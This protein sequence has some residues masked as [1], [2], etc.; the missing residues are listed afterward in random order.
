MDHLVTLFLKLLILTNEK[1]SLDPL[2][3]R[4]HVDMHGRVE[5]VRGQFSLCVFDFALS[6]ALRSCEVGRA[7]P[8]VVVVG[9]E[10]HRS[11]L[12]LRIIAARRRPVLGID[13]TLRKPPARWATKA[14][15]LPPC[16]GAAAVA[17]CSNAPGAEQAFYQFLSKRITHAAHDRGPGTDVAAAACASSVQL[18][19]G[20]GQRAAAEP[21]PWVMDQEARRALMW[22][23]QLVRQIPCGQGAAAAHAAALI[24]VSPA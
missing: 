19:A 22:K 14:F 10:L 11:R 18:R 24:A 4:A 16:A 9:D 17:G 12:C 7:A 23:A 1:C 5:D 20:R 3:Q 2:K 6:Q 13:R 15:W 8:D 21:W